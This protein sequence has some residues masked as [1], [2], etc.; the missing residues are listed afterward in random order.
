MCTVL[1]PPD[2][3]PIELIK[4]ISYHMY[5]ILSAVFEL[6]GGIVSLNTCA[7]CSLKLEFNSAIAIRLCSCVILCFKSSRQ[8]F[9]IC[10]RR[11]V[12]L[13]HTSEDSV[14]RRRDAEHSAVRPHVSRQY[15]I[16]QG[17]VGPGL[18]TPEDDTALPM[19]RRDPTA[20]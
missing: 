10:S 2:V 7:L 9:G 6:I 5:H 3:N 19:K 12:F 4:Y 20:R 13:V 18:S 14:R 11:F 16:L 17:L 1:L 8:N 15:S